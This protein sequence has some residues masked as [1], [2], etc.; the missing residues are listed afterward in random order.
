MPD[1]QMRP[2]EVTDGLITP[3][4]RSSDDHTNKTNFGNEEENHLQIN[5]RSRVLVVIGD[6]WAG[7]TCRT[8]HRDRK[9]KYYTLCSA[10]RLSHHNYLRTRNLCHSIP[11][12]IM[13]KNTF[14]VQNKYRL[15]MITIAYLK[16]LTISLFSAQS[17]S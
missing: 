9:L 15:V 3:R 10:Q 13:S 8:S 4:H 17:C 11:I 16:I 6:R 5:P 7:A 2:D 14:K 1:T 12:R